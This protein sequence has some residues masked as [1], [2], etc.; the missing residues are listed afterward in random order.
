MANSDL[1]GIKG[2]LLKCSQARGSYIV[3]MGSGPFLEARLLPL[4]GLPRVV[5][6]GCAYMR[7]KP[8]LRA[9]PSTDPFYRFT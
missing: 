6:D 8:C 2:T 1:V 9:Y 7:Y 5:D 3:I 4:N